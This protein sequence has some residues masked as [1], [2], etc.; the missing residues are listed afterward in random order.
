MKRTLWV[1][2]VISLSPSLVLAQ[3][4]RVTPGEIVDDRFSK[5]M[6]TGSLRVELSIEGDGKEGVKAARFLPKEAKD[7]TG[8]SLLPNEKDKEKAKDKKDVPFESVD[9]MLKVKVEL[10]NPARKARSFRLAGKLELFVPSK[11]PNAVVKVPG[12]LALRD[13]PLKSPGLKSAKVEVTLLSKKA[14]DDEKKSQKLDDAKIAEIRAEGKKRGVADKEVDAMIELAKAFQNMDSD[15]PEGA[16]ILHGKL[17]DMD[18]IVDVAIQKADG[19]AIDVNGKSST[20]DAKTKTTV[21]NTHEPPPPDAV[22]VFTVLTD[23]AKVTLPVDMKEV[24]LP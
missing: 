20:S 19:T 9:S 21:L 14:Y 17:A 11:D 1:A 2:L 12:A 4:L 3:S 24:P 8:A 15:V 22:L 13:K 16:V 23:K 6:M 10:E 7:D 18:R 5:G